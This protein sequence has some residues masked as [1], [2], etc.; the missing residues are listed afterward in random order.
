MEQ[1][2]CFF[3]CFFKKDVS[4]ICFDCFIYR[5][6][7]LERHIIE[8]TGKYISVDLFN[9]IVNMIVFAITSAVVD[10][11][12]D[13]IVNVLVCSACQVVLFLVCILS[14]G[15][16]QDLQEIIMISVYIII[17]IDVFSITV[18]TIAFAITSVVGNISVDRV[19]N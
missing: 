4:D 3:V 9:I 14:D 16:F 15:L 1:Y 10:L 18:K 17:S 7:L 5:Q 11:S 2:N 8:S 19:M 6:Y 13:R 12:V